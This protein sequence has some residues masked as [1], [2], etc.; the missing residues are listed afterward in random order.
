MLRLRSA[1]WGSRRWA[2]S[3]GPATNCGK[4]ATYVA[5]S[6]ML[7]VGSMRRR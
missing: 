1:I 7:R 4:Y 6:R 2:R 5:K 3:I